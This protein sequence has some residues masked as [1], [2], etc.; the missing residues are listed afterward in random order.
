[1]T[2][3]QQRCSFVEQNKNK[4]ASP[5][6]M[7][8]QLSCQTHQRNF[9]TGKTEQSCQNAWLAKG[10]RPSDS[11]RQCVYVDRTNAGQFAGWMHA[12]ASKELPT[13]PPWLQWCSY[14]LHNARNDS[15]AASAA[16][17]EQPQRLPRQP[18]RMPIQ[19]FLRALAQ[20]VLQ[21]KTIE[22]HVKRLFLGALTRRCCK[23]HSRWTA[24]AHATPL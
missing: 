13:T 10:Q 17:A 18:Q 3:T 8:S 2:S 19:C 15:A 12:L 6:I 21:P 7:S 16:A 20:C 14:D 4:P 1:M 24:T 11:N 23:C 5:S 9:P 22:M